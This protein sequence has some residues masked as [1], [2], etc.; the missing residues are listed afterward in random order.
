MICYVA[1]KT[2]PGGGDAVV[3]DMHTGE[4][5]VFISW[6]NGNHA[7]AARIARGLNLLESLEDTIRSMKE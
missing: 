4:C 6:S 1:D 3:K 2:G 7:K 5:Y